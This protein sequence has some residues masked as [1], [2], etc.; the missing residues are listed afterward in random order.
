MKKQHFS[1]TMTVLAGAVLVLAFQDRVQAVPD[2]VWD[3]FATGGNLGN[4]YGY[5]TPVYAAGTDDAGDAGSAYTVV[6]PSLGGNIMTWF[7]GYDGGN[8]WYVPKPID[9]SQ[10]T[11]LNFDILWDTTS[12]LTI[13]QWNTGTN[14]QSALFTTAEPQNWVANNGWIG[15]IDIQLADSGG[16][17]NGWNGS[18][19]QGTHDLNSVNVPKNAG[20]GWQTISIPL[21]AGNVGSANSE[22][23]I[24]FKKWAAGTSVAP[25]A[26]TATA[27]FWIDNI[28]IK[29]G[30]IAPPPTVLSPV[31][32]IEGLNV[33]NATENNSFYDR[34]EVGAIATSGFSWVGHEPCS[35]SYT[36]TSLPNSTAAYAYMFIIPNAGAANENG[37][38]YNEATALVVDTTRNATGGTST[39][40]TYRVNQPNTEDYT[41]LI[42]GATPVALNSA[43]LAGTYTLTFTSDDGGYM[44]VPDGS[45]ATF[46]FPIAGTGLANFAE[47]GKTCLFYLGGQANNAAAMN[48]AAI[49]TSWSCTGVPSAFTETFAGESSFVNVEASMTHDPASIVLVKPTDRYWV[50]WT[51]PAVGYALENRSGLTSGSFKNTTTYAPIAEAGQNAQLISQ[52]DLVAPT[53]TQEWQL[54]KRNYSALVVQLPG[55]TF[56]SGVGVTGTPSAISGGAP[57]VETATGYAVDAGNNLVTS[58]NSDTCSIASNSDTAAADDFAGPSANPSMAAGVVSFSGATGSFS[59]GNDGLSAPASENVTITDNAKSISGTSANVSLTN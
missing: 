40:V 8:P 15:G 30:T 10:Y 4:W 37:P 24:I 41:N 43:V 7:D 52:S 58:V 33:I 21:N 50:D 2:L 14:W 31:P 54:V 32:A 11:A 49:Y 59:W 29:G 38:D 13:D 57:W 28:I 23:C 51:L 16:Y 55:Q 48:Q 36:L 20:A 6:Q 22:S 45:T 35:Y 27:K 12:T 18:G 17:A 47:T 1:R 3:N 25:V 9:F 39:I 53:G 46:A 26:S 19:S 44:S 5:N 56:T 42:G 34:N